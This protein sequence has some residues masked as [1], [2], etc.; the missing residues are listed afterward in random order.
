MHSHHFWEL[1]LLMK[2]NQSTVK[3][4]ALILLHALSTRQ[5]K[6]RSPLILPNGE[7]Q[8]NPGLAVR[9]LISENVLLIRRFP[10]VNARKT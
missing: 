6:P 9:F 4:E 1:Q 10:C 3:N 2:A 8:I 7:Y 5:E